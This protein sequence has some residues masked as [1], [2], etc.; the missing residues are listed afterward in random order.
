MSVP[1]VFGALVLVA[2]GGLFL[3]AL[4]TTLVLPKTRGAMFVGTSPRRI[5]AALGVLVLC[6][7]ARVVDLGSGDGRIL[8]ALWRRYRVRAVGYEINP[9]AYLLSRVWNLAARVPAEVR[10][11]D[12]M[13][14]DLSEYEVIFCYLFPDVMPQLSEKLRREAL[15]GTLVVSFNF[16]LPGSRPFRVLREGEP[17]YFY[18]L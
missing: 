5:R 7:G 3:Y 10:F 2:L 6:P 1:E 9:L 8:R 18:R 16:P 4:S 12:F 17:I 11:R 15:P 14:A 13:R